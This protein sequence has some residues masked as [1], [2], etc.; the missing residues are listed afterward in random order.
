VAFDLHGVEPARAYDLGKTSS[1]V[2]VGL[3][4]HHL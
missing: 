3:V 1:I 2:L 4:G